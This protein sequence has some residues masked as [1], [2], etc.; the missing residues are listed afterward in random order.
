MPSY[1]STMSRGLTTARCKEMA[2]RLQEF[3][4]TRSTEKEAVV[5]LRERQA[6]GKLPYRD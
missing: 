2:G 6:S 1:W 4:S 3:T 5:L